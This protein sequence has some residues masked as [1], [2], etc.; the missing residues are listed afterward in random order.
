MFDLFSRGRKVP[1]EPDHPIASSKLSKAKLAAWAI[2]IGERRAGSDPPYCSRRPHRGMLDDLPQAETPEPAPLPTIRSFV[3]VIGRLLA[4]RPDKAAYGGAV[5]GGL[6]TPVGEIVPVT[7]ID[8]SDAGE[9][10]AS[11]PTGTD[12]KDTRNHAA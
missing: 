11:A 6:N 10:H 2:V 5:A 7:Y 3:E 12:Q 9:S 8:R 4:S 1:L